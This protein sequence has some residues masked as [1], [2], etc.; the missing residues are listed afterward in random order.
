MI[1]DPRST[2]HLS[3]FYR[4]FIILSL[5]L[6]VFSLILTA[7]PPALATTDPAVTAAQVSKNIRGLAL[8]KAS[9]RSV[10]YATTKGG[11]FANWQHPTPYY[12]GHLYVKRDGY[13]K[14][15]ILSGLNETNLQYDVDS[16]KLSIHEHDDLTDVYYEKSGSGNY[17]L[18]KKTLTPNG[19]VLD[20]T[21]TVLAT[22]SYS[23]SAAD[24]FYA[25]R[26]YVGGFET[27]L[28]FKAG[29][30]NTTQY[31]T[32]DAANISEAAS[33]TLADF[34]GTTLTNIDLETVGP[35]HL[36]LAYTG[37]NN[38][39]NYPGRV[40]RI[41][42][43]SFT[44]YDQ[45]VIG[46][47]RPYEIKSLNIN[48]SGIFWSQYAT[49]GAGVQ[50]WARLN[51]GQV[52]ELTGAISNL[53]KDP[54]LGL[55]QTPDGF[56][57]YYMDQTGSSE[58]GEYPVYAKKLS[59]AGSPTQLSYKSAALA[60]SEQRYVI[61]NATTRSAPTLQSYTAT[62]PVKA[63][64]VEFRPVLPYSVAA[65]STGWSANQN[66]DDKTMWQT[67]ENVNGVF[68]TL[69]DFAPIYDEKTTDLFGAVRRSGGSVTAAGSVVEKYKRALL[70]GTAAKSGYRS[71][72]VSS[73][74]EIL[75]RGFSPEGWLMR[76]GTLT[77]AGPIHY[78]T[79]TSTEK[80]AS[81]SI[82]E[83][84]TGEKIWYAKAFNAGVVTIYN[85]VDKSRTDVTVD[86]SCAVIPR[87]AYGSWLL[88]DCSGNPKVARIVGS[89][90]VSIINLDPAKNYQLGS[91]FLAW[92]QNATFGWADL[93]SP[94]YAEQTL[95]T[96]TKYGIELPYSP[97]SDGS[98]RMVAVDGD[99]VSHFWNLPVTSSSDTPTA[100]ISAEGYFK[101]DWALQATWNTSVR[102]RLEIFDSKGELVYSSRSTGP[103]LQAT[104][105]WVGS[106]ASPGGYYSWKLTSVSSTNDGILFGSQTGTVGHMK[107][108]LAGKVNNVVLSASSSGVKVSVD[109]VLPEGS[110]GWQYA[111]RTVSYNKKTASYSSWQ[112]SSSFI[113]NV[114][115]G[116]LVEV[117]VSATGHAGVSVL[118]TGSGM[119]PYSAEQIVFAGSGFKLV[120]DGRG[121]S[122]RAAVA[123]KTGTLSFVASHSSLTI[124]ASAVKTKGSLVVKS[125]KFSK[126]VKLGKKVKSYKFKVA[127]HAK[128][129]VTVSSG[130]LYQYLLK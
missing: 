82:G 111:Y 61:Y 79:N 113:T 60:V 122:G 96:L 17:V 35:D 128:V 29:Y 112:P 75:V 5:P 33:T 4:K 121:W 37:S 28:V 107:D 6:F 30:G 51:D 38:Y 110:S 99:G 41:P 39:N 88:Y 23:G 108:G 117:Q 62:N 49:N 74:D 129:L 123:K 101:D 47:Y 125:K 87:Q 31:M 104:I 106:A 15:D 90:V 7:A 48:S 36:V 105:P 14:V 68:A 57:M 1:L 64:D 120:K 16:L 18:Y 22:K 100:A 84:L 67:T 50:F 19:P 119:L 70:T 9:S 109:G 27:T 65:S 32:V 97:A 54:G 72:I 95:D 40:A 86:S 94:V 69:P 53:N 102:W 80:I 103:V 20:V 59:V 83:A 42:F 12:S 44:S 2:A 76:T 58:Y 124:K 93:S 126:T 46:S 10:V 115:P 91:N 116:Q 55:V 92:R 8:A 98:G 89:D 63:E 118:G 56:W 52:R 73:T 21:T 66:S 85:V 45:Y 26:S 130:S 81:D 114:S 71:T 3:I 77:S 78:V 25:T 11:H 24:A 43:G 13:P 127:K 34:T